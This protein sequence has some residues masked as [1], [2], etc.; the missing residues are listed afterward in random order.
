MLLH[1]VGHK[2]MFRVTHNTFR[3][4][5]ETVSHYLKKVLFTVEELR[6]RDDQCAN[7]SNT[8]EDTNEF[9]LVSIFHVSN[10]VRSFRLKIVLV[11]CDYNCLFFSPQDCINAFDDSSHMY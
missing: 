9:N 1:V 3:R 5:I 4:S 10:I 8:I 6:G 7:C 11:W 2:K